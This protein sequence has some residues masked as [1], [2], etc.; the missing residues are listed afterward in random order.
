[1][2][3]SSAAYSKQYIEKNISET[4]GFITYFRA[5]S[6]K[7]RNL[8]GPDYLAKEFHTGSARLKLNLSPIL[9]PI[10]KRYIPGTYEWV[11]SRTFL[12]DRIFKEALTLNFD[13]I[14][15][16]GAGFDSRAYRFIDY[17]KATK[18]FEVDL[19]PTQEKKIE[20]LK[21]KNIDIPDEMQFVAIN[22]NKDKLDDRLFES[23]FKKDKKNL[24]IWEGVTEYLKDETVDATLNFIKENSM[25]KSLIAFTYI[26]RDV[27]EGNYKYYGSKKIANLVSKYGEPYHFGIPEGG[28]N[29]FLKKLGFRVIKNYTPEELEKIYL[30]FSNGKSFGKIASHQCAVIAEV[31]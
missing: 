16:M 29:K 24:F 13:Q 20:I 6:N 25:E 11:V 12:F 15:I 10:L 4:A 9:L 26:Y 17:I 27:I 18:I 1:M 2:G 3:G 31:L 14:I 30:T 5:C 21:E 28:I 7:E 22:F 23:G 8:K 19:A